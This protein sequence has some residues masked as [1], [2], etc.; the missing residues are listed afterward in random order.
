MQ[1][2]Q[3]NLEHC[4]GINKLNFKFDFKRKNIYAIYSPNGVMKTS[5]AKTFLDISEN[6]ETTDLIFP[7]SNTVRIIKDENGNDIQ[8]ENIFVVEPY[9][10]SFKS[11]KVSTLLV[12][13]NL[14]ENYERIHLNIDEKKELLIKSLIKS[15]GLKSEIEEILSE[16]Y[17]SN[18]NEFFKALLR[19]KDEVLNE[20]PPQF[21]NIIYKNVFSDKIESL[22]NSDNVKNKLHEY[23]EKYDDL[24]GKS[25]FFKKGIF[26]HTNASNIAKQLKSNGFFQ[27]NHSVRLNGLTEVKSEKE[28]EE[29]IEKEKEEIL[30]SPDLIALF[31]TIDKKLSAN[32]D[33]QE[34]RDYLLKNILIVPELSNL[35]GF[36]DKLWVSYLKSAKDLYNDLLTEYE[37]GKVEIEGIVNQA[38]REITQWAKVIEEFNKRFSVPFKLLIGNQEQVILNSEAPVIKFEFIDRKGTKPVEENDLLKVLSIGEKRALYLLN[39]IFEVEARKSDNVETIFIIDDIA[40]SF[41]YKNKYAIIQYLKDISEFQI[42]KQI[43][44]SHNYDFFRTIS[45]RLDMGRENKLNTDRNDSEI[46]IYQEKYQNNPFS[47]WKTKL[48]DEEKMLIASIPFIR[49]LAEFTGNE[50]IFSKLTSLL[51]YKNDSRSIQFS[52][53]ES[54]IKTILVDQNHLS[55]NKTGSVIDEIFLVADSITTDGSDNLDLENKICLSIA[56]RLKAEIFMVNAINDSLFWNS[57]TKNQAHILTERYKNDFPNETIKFKIYSDEKYPLDI[58]ISDTFRFE[59]YEQQ[60]YFNDTKIEFENLINRVVYIHTKNTKLIEGFGIRFKHSFF[61]LSSIILKEL[62]IFTQKILKILYGNELDINYKI[63]YSD[64]KLE[65]KEEN[66]KKNKD[67]QFSLAGYS[68]NLN[69]ILSFSIISTF[70][71]SISK[72]FD[73][74]IKLLEDITGNSFFSLTF[75]VI[76]LFF[77]ERILQGTLESLCFQFARMEFNLKYKKIKI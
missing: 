60:F 52:E 63:L 28:L 45:S 7:E 32:K 68:T 34:F 42:F 44:L 33:T 43:I 59:F 22:L 27:A 2:L 15:S 19:V 12:N 20:E 47:H 72:Y 37:K 70:A 4:Y 73:F 75:G 67:N 69:T 30:T 74:K 3:L 66:T 35:N 16:V 10:E 40:D 55:I 14:R 13:R 48:A 54:I 29:L 5:L 1:L 8:P 39:I 41:D 18:K 62:K 6:R 49:N 57:I 56:I 61:N 31:N 51:H 64:N 17:T 36:K 53:L 25:K 77:Y 21:D 65:K 46:K 71:Y 50:N 58:E 11:K 76:L 38:K 23:I 9:N 26:N 24:L